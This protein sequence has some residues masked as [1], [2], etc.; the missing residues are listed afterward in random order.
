MEAKS[1]H[2]GTE[3]KAE[4]KSLKTGVTTGTCAA[5]AAKAAAMILKG[6]QSPETVDIT[7]PDGSTVTLDVANTEQTTDGAS[8]TVK[9]YAGDDPDVTD[10]VLVHVSVSYIEGNE[11]VIAAG[12]G[13]GTVTKPGLAIPPGQPAINPAPR[14]MITQ[15]VRE[16]TN[17]GVEVTVSI[18]GGEELARKTFNPRLGIVGGLSVL[19]TSGIVRPFSTSA[20]RD[21]LKCSLSVVWACKIR[22]PVLVPGRIGSRAAQRHFGVSDEHVV[23]VS[24]EW[25]FMLEQSLQYDFQYLLV[26]GHPGKMAK[27]ADN[28]WDTHSKRSRSAIPMVVSM[29]EHSLGRPMEDAITV[30]GIFARLDKADSDKLGSKLADAVRQAVTNRI[31][32]KFPVAAALVNLQG[33]L[34]GVSGDLS[35]WRDQTT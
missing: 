9:K 10:G 6:M 1:H 12:I 33:D 25:G 4:D 14:S 26:M 5:G 20:L 27:L 34:L 35:P 19:G 8:A 18:P 7:L 3:F 15:A 16:V 2:D 30:E 32:N 11:V 21:S 13:V 17:R 22:N 31:K 24:N 23:E 29:A 28:Q